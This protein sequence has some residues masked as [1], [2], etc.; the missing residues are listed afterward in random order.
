MLVKVDRTSMFTSL[1]CRAPFLNKE[2]WNFTKEL[3]EKFLMNGLDKKI[4]LKDS[5]KKYFPVN[6]LDKSKKG[7]GIPVGDWL[8]DVFK[9]ELLKYSKSDFLLR[10]KIFKVNYIKKLVSNHLSGVSDNTFKV[11]AFYC[12]QKWYLNN[13]KN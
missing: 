6:F 11:W 10:Q 5:F 4:L 7:F 1:E 13:F 3:P 9:D 12:F 2:I 8:R